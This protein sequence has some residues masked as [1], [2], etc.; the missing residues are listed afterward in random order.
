MSLRDRAERKWHNSGHTTRWV[1]SHNCI[2]LTAVLGDVVGG[3]WLAIAAILGGDT[4][5]GLEGWTDKSTWCYRP[6]RA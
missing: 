6:N 5:N 4:G 2:Y 1:I 3:F